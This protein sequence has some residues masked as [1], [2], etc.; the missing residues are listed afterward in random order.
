VKLDKVVLRFDGY[1]KEAV[2]ESNLE[3]WRKRQVIIFYY[4]ED[5][6]LMINEPKQV[7]SGT[8]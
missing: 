3:N 7:N 8:P 2:V 6:T 4:L 1:F 5:S